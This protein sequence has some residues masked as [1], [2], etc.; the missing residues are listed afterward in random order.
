M[1][2]RW[3]VIAFVVLLVALVPTVALAQD[4]HRGEILGTNV[5]ILG[6]PFEVNGPAKDIM[7]STP[8]Q[9]T[10][11]LPATA[12]QKLGLESSGPLPAKGKTLFSVK[13]EFEGVWPNGNWRTYDNNG[14]LGGNICWDDENWIA[15]H[16][17]WSGWGAGGCANGLDPNHNYYVDN[18]D[19]WT[20]YGPFSTVGAKKAAV[21]FWYWNDTEKN[22]DY[23]MWCASANGVNF[24]CKN[25]TG[26]TNNKWKRTTLNLK[27]VP[28]YGN[29]LN[30]SSVWVAWIM[31]TDEDVSGSPYNGSF[32]DGVAITVTK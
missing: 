27:G 26:S 2:H 16:G 10:A 32:I 1:K 4:S 8:G 11:V 18:M 29:M 9:K 22:Y 5:R 21:K 14:A 19:S 7:P 23:L 20:V 12:S 24:Y 30:D 28:G 25:T 15:E 3:L 6:Q 13:E 31:T 17:H